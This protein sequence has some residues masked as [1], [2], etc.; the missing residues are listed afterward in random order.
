MAWHGAA[1]NK[2]SLKHNPN[3]RE[4]TPLTST[5][6]N[7]M[8]RQN[9]TPECSVCQHAESSEMQLRN[10]MSQRRPHTC[11]LERCGIVSGKATRLHAMQLITRT[12]P[13]SQPCS[14]APRAGAACRAASRRM[15]AGPN[16]Q[17]NDKRERTT[18]SANANCVRNR[19]RGSE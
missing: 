5:H 6:C 18:Q 9:A 10:A 13:C 15:K 12:H 16:D 19:N 8:Q 14:G 7:A 1:C 3:R 17:S 11:P 2:A 4:E